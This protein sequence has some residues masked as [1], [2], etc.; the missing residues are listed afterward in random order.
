MRGLNLG[1]GDRLHPD[2]TNVDIVA[3]GP[4]VRRC[5]LVAGIPFAAE[6]FDVVYHSH[7]LEHLPKQ[8]APP[9]LRDCCRVLKRGGVVRVVVPDFEQ[10]ARTYLDALEG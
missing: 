6:T 3:S 4:G 1:C 2:W 7:L 8:I 10:I 9:F 5:D